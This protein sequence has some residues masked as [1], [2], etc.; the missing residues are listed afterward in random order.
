MPALINPPVGRLPVEQTAN[1]CFETMRAY[2][3]RIFRLEPH[4]DRLCASA[5]H[6]GLRSAIDRRRLRAMLQQTLADS[7]CNEAVVRIALMPQ[8]PFGG[9]IPRAVHPSVVVQ[10]ANPLPASVY[11]KGIRVAIVPTK[12]F[13]VNAIDPQIKYSA[14]LS[15]VMATTE[16]HLRGV[17]EALFL[18]AL[19]SVTESTASNF[20]VV[21]GGVIV[22]PPCWL[23]LLS[24][25]TREV[26]V[27]LALQL[28]IPLRE[29][30]LTR[31]EVYTANE[32]FMSST[33]KEVLSVTVVD[34]R[35]IGDG[36]PGPI[37]RR[38]LTA[39]RELVKKELT[40]HDV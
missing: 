7:G 27:E 32:A 15:S 34:G 24:G 2:R 16:A 18:D 14:R 33:L 17:D 8:R 30:P 35:V 4:L 9:G 40:L 3:G 37:T 23:G 25:I 11:R 13:P 31:H 10:P 39:F 28:R 29:E 21:R 38:L 6:L 20:G 5:Q 22:T 36:R 19:G 12:K 1:G 26:I